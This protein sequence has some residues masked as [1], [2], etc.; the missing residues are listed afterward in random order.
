MSQA[1]E[2]G[3]QQSTLTSNMG[4]VSQYA[5]AQDSVVIESIVTSVETVNYER[6]AHGQLP[7]CVSML[8]L[9]VSNRQYAQHAL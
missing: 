1:D 4:Q 8:L 3:D 2:Y 6:P 9:D 5:I 7:K